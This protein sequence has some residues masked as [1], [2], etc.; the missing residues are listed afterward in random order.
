[1]ICFC[2]RPTTSTARPTDFD[3]AHRKGRLL[4]LLLL[5]GRRRLEEDGASGRR[6]RR[7]LR[8]LGQ[9]QVVEPLGHLLGLL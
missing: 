3:D 8:L 2:W 4:L 5:L 6:R 1:L 9:Q 7:R